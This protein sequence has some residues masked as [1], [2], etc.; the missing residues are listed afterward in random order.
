VRVL[1]GDRELRMPGW[2][3]PT[4]RHIASAADGVRVGDLRALDAESRLV[5]VRRLVREG[6]LEV[7]G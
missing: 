1:L 4:L 7:V 2:L 6:L 5:L 3:E